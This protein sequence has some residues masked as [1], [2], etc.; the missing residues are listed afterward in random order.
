MHKSYWKVLMSW[1]GLNEIPF[2][3]TYKVVAFVLCH[4]T[5]INSG[6]WCRFKQLGMMTAF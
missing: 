5:F 1:Y 4:M 2:N 6:L 3:K